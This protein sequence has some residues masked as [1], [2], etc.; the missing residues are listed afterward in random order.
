MN[1]FSKYQ[2][3]GNDYLI[4]DST[5]LDFEVT[6]AAAQMLCGRNF[7]VGADGVLVTRTLPIRHDS[8]IDVAIFNSDGSVC[9]KSGNGLRM[10]ALH[11]AR[12]DPERWCQG[13]ALYLRTVAGLSL[14]QVTDLAAGEV[15]INMGAPDFSAAAVPMVD[16]KLRRWE[17]VASGVDLDLDGRHVLSTS[18]SLGTPHTVVQLNEITRKM[19]LELGPLIAHHPRFPV[20]TNVSFM[21]AVDRSHIEIEIWERAAGYSLASGASACACAV[22][23]QA[24]GLI[25]SE[26]T[27]AMP[28]GSLQVCVA[29]GTV[30]MTGLVEHVLDGT[31]A[32]AFLR[33]LSS[34]SRERRAS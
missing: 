3:L 2:A 13:K 26:V 12:R 8:P 15:G 5:K 20:G 14:V 1:G 21:K 24:T 22:V 23:A 18:L 34:Q 6:S 27:V 31:L 16:A 17:E 33:R 25:D 11:L 32:P 19:A 9:G 7:G 28:G 29:D 10:L 4:V 30:R